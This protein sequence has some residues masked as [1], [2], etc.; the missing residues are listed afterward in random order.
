MFYKN[1]LGLNKYTSNVSVFGELGKFPLH[2]F[3]KN[4]C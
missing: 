1:L 3:V 4:D 2:F